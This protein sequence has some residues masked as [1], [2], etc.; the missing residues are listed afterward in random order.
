MTEC[1]KIFLK[2]PRPRPRVA[3]IAEKAR[4]SRVL[5]GG[6]GA[7]ESSGINAYSKSSGIL[8]HSEFRVIMASEATRIS[9]VGVISCRFEEE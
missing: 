8:K 4:G 1:G 2:R 3:R 7:V 9:S 6:G 5:G